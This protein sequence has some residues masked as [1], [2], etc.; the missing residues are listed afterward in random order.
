MEISTW[1]SLFAI[2]TLGAMS[3]GPSTAIIIQ[4]TIRN[5]RSEGVLA[6]V[7]H[8]IGVGCYALLTAAGLA[9]VMKQSPV[10]FEGLKLLGAGF[11]AYLGCKALGLNLHFLSPAKNQATDNHKP[12]PF[13]SNGFV[14]GFLTAALNPKVAFFFLAL[15]S[16]FVSTDAGL[17]EKLIMISTAAIV[18]ALWYCLVAVAASNKN[19][20][21]KFSGY[22]YWLEKIFGGLLIALAIRVALE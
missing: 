4:T 10:L 11:L 2:C 12:P 3:P 1:L 22:G 20:T 13:S 9:V 17:I 7:G 19:I 6:G 15:F 16:Q 18:D 21:G 8:G 14:I 5:G